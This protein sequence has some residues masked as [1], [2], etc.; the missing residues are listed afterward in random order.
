MCNVKENNYTYFDSY[1]IYFNS[2]SESNSSEILIR[3]FIIILDSLTFSFKN[4]F[5]LLSIKYTDPVHAYFN[6]PIYY[7]FQ[8]IVLLIINAIVDKKAF[9]NTSNYMVAKYC[10]DLSGDFFCLI[11]FLIYLEIIELNFCGLNNNLK[12]YITERSKTEDLSLFNSLDNETNEGD[13]ENKNDIE[14]I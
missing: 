8:K 5:L 11:G 6:I 1:K 13:E 2:F 12:K 4:Y 14:M 10:L 3:T 9:L 7:V